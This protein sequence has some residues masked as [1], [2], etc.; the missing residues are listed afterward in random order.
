MTFEERHEFEPASETAGLFAE[1]A[2]SLSRANAACASDDPA[3]MA[4]V[5]HGDVDAFTVIVERYTPQVYRVCRRMLNGGSEA[6]DI[7]Q[8]TFAKLW[9]TAPQWRAQGG[10]LPAWLHRVAVNRCL[11]R[12][13]QFRLVT[14]DV[15]PEVADDAPG[16]ERA[17]AM[18]RLGDAVGEALAA[19]PGRHRAAIVLCYFEG[20]SNILAA[21]VLELNLKAM[22]SLLFR[23]R[24]NLRELLEARGVRSDDLELLA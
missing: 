17:L 8:E 19:M 15:I 3:L 22:E 9:Q 16:P 10:G 7:A 6:E 20:L 14:T 4:R 5:G 12:L 2:L 18:R 1:P 24:R 13:R 21:D 11:D 23:A